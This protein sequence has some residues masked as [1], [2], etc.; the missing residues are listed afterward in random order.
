MKRILISTLGLCLAATTT[1]ADGHASGD[2]EAGA[3]VFNQCKACHSIVDD[4]ENVILRG[5]VNGP[6]LYGIYT[7][8]AGTYPDFRY[9]DALVEAGEM[10]LEWNEAD[11]LAYTADP[12]SFLREYTD[13]RR[14]R[15]NMAFRLRSEEDSANVWAYLVSVGPEVVAEDG[16]EEAESN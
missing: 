10:G 7:R 9:G 1:F 11:F 2:A 13:D 4:E 3:A 5:G 14:A 16:E 12:R 15:T 8:Q 6:N